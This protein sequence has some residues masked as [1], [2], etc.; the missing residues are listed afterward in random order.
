MDFTSLIPKFPNG[1]YSEKIVDKQ[2]TFNATL[3]KRAIVEVKVFNP[4]EKK[5]NSLVSSRLVQLGVG[6]ITY[7]YFF[8][9]PIINLT[10]KIIEKIQDNYVILGWDKETGAEVE[11]SDD[12]KISIWASDEQIKISLGTKYQFQFEKRLKE[13]SI[14]EFI[15]WLTK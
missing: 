14:K 10:E 2:G 15:E 11:L 9:P 6:K 4:E 1:E 13:F 7:E 8:S 3:I 5:V 12:L